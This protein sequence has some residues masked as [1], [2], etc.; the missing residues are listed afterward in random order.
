MSADVTADVHGNIQEIPR[1]QLSSELLMEL[2]F[3]CMYELVFQ[4]Y[5]TEIIREINLANEF[6]TRICIITSQK[7]ILTI[8]TKQRIYML[9][10]RHQLSF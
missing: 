8:Y 7:F 1:R 9:T 6:I 5:A 3:H 2:V 4:L 10:M